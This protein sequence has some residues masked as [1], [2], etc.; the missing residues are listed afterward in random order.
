[1]LRVLRGGRW[2]CKDVP[3]CLKLI[4]YQ[5]R[6]VENASDLH[7]EDNPL[8]KSLLQGFQDP[9]SHCD[10]GI[11]ESN[12]RCNHSRAQHPSA[13]HVLY[14]QRLERAIE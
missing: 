4:N 11:A 7:A 1:M 8:L 3:I 9:P 6:F 2:G 14:R 13:L 10:T 12:L 5:T